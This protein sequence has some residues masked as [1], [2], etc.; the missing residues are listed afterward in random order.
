MKRLVKV[1]ID[2]KS[3]GLKMYP[4]K[5]VHKQKWVLEVYTDSEWAGDKAT[6]KSVS[7]YS[8]NGRSYPMEIQDSKTSG[9][10]KFGSGVLCTQ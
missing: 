5:E 10:V 1:V 7:G 8:A 3:Y 4:Y 6:R 2:T 9:T